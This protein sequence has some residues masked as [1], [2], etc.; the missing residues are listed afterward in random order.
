[1]LP[2]IVSSLLAQG[3]NL[4]ANAALAKGQE[5]IEGHTGVDLSK[6]SL[7]KDDLMKLKQFELEHEQELL[8]LRIEDDRLG[9]ER[10]R[11]YLE[12]IQSARQ[13][14]Q[15]ALQSNDTF[16]SRFVYY[17]ALFWSIAAICYIGAIT[18]GQIP[19]SNVRFA[20]T[21]LGFLLGT[22]LGQIMAFLYGS[23]RSSQ[24]KDAT[25]SSVVNRT[26][27]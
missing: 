18:F 1:M 4:V 23:S 26:S 5:W 13:M 19:E 6:A 2:A 3:L 24:T 25:I 21:I 7:S 12:D 27:K 9:I 8:K 22:I 14:H 15:V 16:A 17:F 11:V 20:D 10:V